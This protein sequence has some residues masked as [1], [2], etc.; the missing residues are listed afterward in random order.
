MSVKT[1]QDSVYILLAGTNEITLARDY[2]AEAY[3]IFM[4]AVESHK[5]LL[6][7][8]DDMTSP[9]YTRQSVEYNKKFS[10]ALDKL[11]DLKE[12]LENYFSN[13]IFSFE[14]GDIKF[15]IS[16]FYKG[17]DLINYNISGHADLLF[18]PSL[19][20]F[21]NENGDTHILSD[22]YNHLDKFK[23]QFPVYKAPFMR[24]GGGKKKKGSRRKSKKFSKRKT[25]KRK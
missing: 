4:S 1:L 3:K 20:A 21:I 7:S 14:E 2:Q 6:D 15:K 8:I 18:T 11:V 5:K 17:E 10:I 22:T 16:R 13:M 24:N 25:I 19:C 9:V 23:K 12:E